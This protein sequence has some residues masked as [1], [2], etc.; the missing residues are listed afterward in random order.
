MMGRWSGL[1]GRFCD[2][3]RLGAQDL[4]QMLPSKLERCVPCSPRGVAQG[5]LATCGLGSQFCS[6]EQPGQQCHELRMQVLVD[7]STQATQSEAL[8][9]L[10]MGAKQMVL[11]GD[12]CQ[13]GPVIMNR[14]VGFTCNDWLCIPRP[15]TCDCCLGLR[16]AAPLLSSFCSRSP[17]GLGLG[18][19]GAA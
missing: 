15:H 9:A 17:Q 18:P 7:E 11:V 12:H 14:K 2:D 13:L 5:A 19:L 3:S 8:I 1:P 4:A 10:V 6:T 16:G